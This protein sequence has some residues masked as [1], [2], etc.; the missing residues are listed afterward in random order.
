M[1]PFPAR[2]GVSLKFR[3]IAVIVIVLIAGLLI[4]FQGINIGVESDIGDDGDTTVIIQNQNT[5]QRLSAQ[6]S[7]SQPST[8]E[9]MLM[10]FLGQGIRQTSFQPLGYSTS[11]DNVI[12]PDS[13]YYIWASVDVEVTADPSYYV[14]MLSSSVTFSG[15]AGDGNG[16]T[17]ANTVLTNS[18]GDST[19]EIRNKIHLN[20]SSPDHLDTYE[21]LGDDGRF[22][23]V[24]SGVSAKMVGEELHGLLIRCT[25]EVQI[26]TAND[27][28]TTQSKTVTLRITVNNWATEPVIDI[29]DI[30]T[31][32]D[33]ETNPQ[34]DIIHGS[35]TVG[36]DGWVNVAVIYLS[37][38]VDHDPD[39]LDMAQAHTE[40]ELGDE[41][42]SVQSFY[43]Q[44]SITMTF[45]YYEFTL[46]SVEYS[47]DVYIQ[48]RNMV[49][50]W[51]SEYPNDLNNIYYSYHHLCFLLQMDR[52]LYSFGG[53]YSMVNI[54]GGSDGSIM[55][56]SGKLSGT[57]AHEIA[58]AFGAMDHYKGNGGQGLDCEDCLMNKL[59]GDTYRLTKETVIC[60]VGLEQI[61]WDYMWKVSR[62]DLN[63]LGD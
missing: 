16:G 45:D 27:G 25:V 19:L 30:D 61:H 37:Y 63:R 5:G 41:Y 38:G 1:P 33:G 17:K 56:T 54:Y 40:T 8:Q 3:G 51:V 26:L 14:S 29:V 48:S 28:T 11:L 60:E 44:Y 21:C 23:Y 13:N 31:N 12:D 22:T 9:Q 47:D 58:H 52:Y 20:P 36:V 10:D 18:F 55:Q 62:Y 34:G 7:L 46:S 43:T 15:E 4:A 6:I 24:N 35:G 53:E 42:Y 57:I 2:G 32:T 50:S 39:V 59:G 49:S